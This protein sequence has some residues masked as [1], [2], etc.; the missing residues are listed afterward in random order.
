[1]AR[2]GDELA[3]LR[4]GLAE[5]RRSTTYHHQGPIGP[6]W[7]PKQNANAFLRSDDNLSHSMAVA[8]CRATGPPGQLVDLGYVFALEQVRDCVAQMRT[9]DV[10]ICFEAVEA[11]HTA[12][13]Q[14]DPCRRAAVGHGLHD[15]GQ[16]GLQISGR[17]RRYVLCVVAALAEF[18][19]G[20]LE[21]GGQRFAAALAP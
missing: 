6:E 9:A 12:F 18:D 5:I 17:I 16:E 11:K 3:R 21:G 2:G 7:V 14:I 20:P 8:F 1:M 13:R 19:G 4:Q 15:R 10:A